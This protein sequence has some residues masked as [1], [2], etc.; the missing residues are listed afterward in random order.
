MT[1]CENCTKIFDLKDDYEE[2]LS[3]NG[4]CHNNDPRYISTT[5]LFCGGTNRD[6][7]F[8]L[9]HI[10]TCNAR[11]EN[12][13][14]Q[15]NKAIDLLID[16]LQDIKK[17]EGYVYLVQPEEFEDTNVYKIGCSSKTDFSWR[18]KYGGVY[19]VLSSQKCEF[20]FKLKE[21]IR[22]SFNQKFK[23]Y[24]GKEYYQGNEE[25]IMYQFH[26][27]IREYVHEQLKLVT[28]LYELI[29]DAQE[30]EIFFANRRL[31]EN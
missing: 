8:L 11:P 9:N 29:D 3:T 23:I 24:K 4:F 7:I 22:Q 30:H 17:N 28:R 19:S 2:H 15:L 14:E 13:L 10:K 1:E 20:P 31:L 12:K 16:K 26:K 27:Q 6:E 18:R 25:S 5:C 21:Q